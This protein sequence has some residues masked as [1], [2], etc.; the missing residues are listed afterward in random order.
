MAQEA[1]SRTAKQTQPSRAQRLLDSMMDQ[2]DRSVLIAAHR[3]GYTND[4]ADDAPENSVANVAVAVLKGYEVFETDIQRTSDGV[5]VMAHDP[6]LE[7]E[8]NG[9]DTDTAES[10][11]LKEL[12]Q[13]RKRFRDKTVSNHK[14]ATLTELLDAG[15]GKILFKTRS[16]TGSH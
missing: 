5:F 9:T 10:K 4:V 6:T 15:N 11:T 12:Q 2:E 13:L 16:E 3:G 14:I 8:T 1:A 7:R